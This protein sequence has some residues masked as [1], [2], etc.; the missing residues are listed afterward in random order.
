MYIYFPKSFCYEQDVTQ[1]QFLRR[2]KLVWMQNFTSLTL[3]AE[4]KLKD[5][6]CFTIYPLLKTEQKD[7]YVSQTQTAASSISFPTTI[8]IIWSMPS[9]SSAYD[10][11]KKKW[12]GCSNSEPDIT[13]LHC[14]KGNSLSSLM[15]NE[16]GFRYQVILSLLIWIW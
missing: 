3:V 11:N 15:L 14:T 12:F 13:P 10:N 6:I 4:T 1:C 2:R 9:C 5:P 16:T 8:T 7:T